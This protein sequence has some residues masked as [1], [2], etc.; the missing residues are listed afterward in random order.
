MP[1]QKN[2][3]TA[4]DQAHPPVLSMRHNSFQT[5]YP[6]IASLKMTVQEGTGMPGVIKKTQSFTENDF[7]DTVDCSNYACK[8]GGA[9]L[10][11]VLA[12]A[13]DNNVP[14]I[15]TTLCCAGSEATRRCDHNFHIMATI[16]YKSEA[17]SPNQ[18]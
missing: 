3:L 14:T 7:R 16:I 2:K 8:N 18:S 15:D 5:A 11:R 13:V 10:R 4:F 6:S 12:D 9:Y 1:N 17:S